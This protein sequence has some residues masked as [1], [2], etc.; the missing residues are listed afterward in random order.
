MATKIIDR[1]FAL[2]DLLSHHPKGMGVT[3]IAQ[4]LSMPKAT[5]HRLLSDLME[6]GYVEL[7]SPYTVYRLTLKLVR[8]AFLSL[9][10][11]T[12]LESSQHLLHQLAQRSGE[13]VRLSVVDGDKLIYIAKAQ[14]ATSGLRID[15]DMG[16]EAKLWHSATGYAWLSTLDNDKALELVQQQLAAFVAEET[17][18]SVPLTYDEKT[19][20][21][22]LASARING[23]SR[24]DNSM[25]AGTTAMAMPVVLPHDVRAIGVVSIAGPSLRL[26]AQKMDELLPYL[27]ETTQTLAAISLGV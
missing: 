6:L 12:L 4:A 15:T 8:T 20:L 5:T 13:L 14:G 10:S 7:V 1:C 3:D 16:H 9:S 2:L 21:A 27:R 26:T 17:D 23:Y 22:A 11:H 24:I 25:G 19:M 18:G